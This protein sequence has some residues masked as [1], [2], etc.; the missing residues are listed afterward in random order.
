[1]FGARTRLEVEQPLRHGFMGR[2]AAHRLHPVR[3]LRARLGGLAECFWRRAG[4]NRG[5]RQAALATHRERE[6]LETRGVFLRRRMRLVRVDFLRL[7]TER[8]LFRNHD[9]DAA[10]FRDADPVLAIRAAFFVV[11]AVGVVHAPEAERRDA[12]DQRERDHE[13]RLRAHRLARPERPHEFVGITLRLRNL[14]VDLLHV[15]RGLGVLQILVVIEKAV[16]TRELEAVRRM[17]IEQPIRAPFRNELR[18]ARMHPDFPRGIAIG[19]EQNRLG[20]RADDRD[21]AL[22]P[23]PDEIRAPPVLLGSARHV[24]RHPLTG[25]CRW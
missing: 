14:R 10:A 22:P 13:G 5:R 9:L 25:R 23:G 18:G 17:Q 3:I 7:V 2:D 24:N 15:D 20:M 11:A 4:F 21:L 12:F 1:M 6:F 8:R 19:R 16:F